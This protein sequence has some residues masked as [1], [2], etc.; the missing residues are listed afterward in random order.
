MHCEL[1]FSTSQSQYR[2][3]QKRCINHHM[4][5]INSHLHGRLRR[6]LCTTS[7]I[8]QSTTLTWLLFTFHPRH[9]PA[10]RNNNN[11]SPDKHSIHIRQR[12]AIVTLHSMPAMLMLYCTIVVVILSLTPP[13]LFTNTNLCLYLQRGSHVALIVHRCVSLILIH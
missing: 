7:S 1:E 11:N 13:I 6:F 5:S 8:Q 12:S 3:N 2:N 10:T 9:P 4:W